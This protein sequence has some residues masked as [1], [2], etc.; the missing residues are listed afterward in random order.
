MGVLIVSE[1]EQEKIAAMIAEA[2][3]NYMPWSIA[4]HGAVTIDDGYLPLDKR[5]PGFE[6]PPSQH[7]VLGT[8]RIAFSFEEQ[9]QGICRHLSVS[10]LPPQPDVL[11]GIAAVAEICRLFAFENVPEDGGI[12]LEEYEPGL[13]AVNVVELSERRN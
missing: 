10:T 3:E 1:A 11:P 5:I 6:R 7:I 9:P 13:F 4:Q 2:R 8:Y 12:W